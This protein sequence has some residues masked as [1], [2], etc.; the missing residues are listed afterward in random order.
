VLSKN[1]QA[2]LL[3]F[4]YH[5]SLIKMGIATLNS[6]NNRAVLRAVGKKITDLKFNMSTQKHGQG[7][8]HNFAVTY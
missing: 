4:S 1:Q 3:S 7:E 8:L 2:I 5:I 6:K